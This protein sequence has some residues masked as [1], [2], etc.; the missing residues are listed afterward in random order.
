[1]YGEDY[2]ASEQEEELQSPSLDR[3]PS[4]LRQRTY[5]PPKEEDLKEMVL[6]IVQE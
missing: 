3:S 4:L 2:E 6:K 5:K 1:V